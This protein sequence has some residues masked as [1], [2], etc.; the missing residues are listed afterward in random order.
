M[1]MATRH[2][3]RLLGMVAALLLMTTGLVVAAPPP[4]AAAAVQSCSSSTPVSSRPTLRRGD[5]GSCV[6]VLQNLLL[7]KGYAIGTSY[8]DGSFG[9]GTELGVRRYQS[10][11]LD[12]VIDG[13]VGPATW[14]RLVNGGGTTYSVYKGPNTTSR[15]ILSFDD[16]PTS[17]SAFKATVVG[18]RNLGIALVLAPT[19]NCISAGRFS[20]SYARSY[21]HYV[22]NHSVSHPDF[23]TLT[24]S[25]IY[26][27]LGSPGVVTSYGRPPYG[28]VDTRVRNAF[29]T[30]SMRIWLWNVDT[31]DWTGKTRSQVVSYV[32]ANAKAGNTVLMHMGWNAFNTTALSSMKSGLAAKGIGVCRNSGGTTPTRPSKVNC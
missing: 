16:C 6:K 30:K 18:A 15:V 23:T 28:A 21:G 17:L 4:T 27:Q 7:A 29:A 1:I 9:P 31:N 12:L 5:T 20:A 11:K 22:I 26:Y 10:S 14:N 25:Q 13:V 8:A 3:V 24:T 32:V 2:A 19:G